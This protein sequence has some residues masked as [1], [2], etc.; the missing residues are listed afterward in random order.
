M[1]KLRLTLQAAWVKEMLVE[2]SSLLEFEVE[3]LGHVPRELRE[4]L[5][6]FLKCPSEFFS[7]DCKSR[8]ASGTNECRILLKPSDGLLNLVLALRAWNRERNVAV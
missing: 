1:K 3:S 8:V 5:L 7:F 6:Q 2:I 4:R